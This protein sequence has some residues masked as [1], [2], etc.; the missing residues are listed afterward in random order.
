[1]ELQMIFDDGFLTTSEKLVA[2]LEE[3]GNLVL[4]LD[5]YCDGVIL[6]KYFSQRKVFA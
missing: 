3:D 1:M 6:L 5:A 4:K 2:I